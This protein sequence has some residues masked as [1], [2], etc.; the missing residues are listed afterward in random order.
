MDGLLG[1]GGR[2]TRAEFLARRLAG[3]CSRINIANDTQPLFSLAECR[4]VTHV[5]TETLASL[6]EATA[7]EEGKP[8]QLFLVRLGKCHRRRR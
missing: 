1:R 6:L 4:E 5:K 7:H 2:G 8:L 3:P